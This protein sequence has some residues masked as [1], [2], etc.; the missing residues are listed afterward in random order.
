[1]SALLRSVFIAAV[2]SFAQVFDVAQQ[3]HGQSLLHFPLRVSGGAPIVKNVTKRQTEVAIEDQLNGYFYS[4]DVGVG[5]PKQT[6]TVNFDTGSPELWINPDC[7]QAQNPKFCESLGHFNESSTF[8]GLG[9]QGTILYGT[10]FVR[11]N[12]SYDYVAVGCG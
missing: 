7:S 5:T 9:T 6:V 3:S 10:G 4:I 1:M 2:P 12:Y 8:V 11:F